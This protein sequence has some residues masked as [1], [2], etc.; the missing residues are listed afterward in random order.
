M[1]TSDHTTDAPAGDKLHKRVCLPRRAVVA[2]VLLA[3]VSAFAFAG[4][5][6]LGSLLFLLIVGLTAFAQ[7]E[8]I[9]SFGRMFGQ[10]RRD[11][12]GHRGSHLKWWWSGNAKMTDPEGKEEESAPAWY[13]VALFL[14]G[15]GPLAVTML[16]SPLP[17]WLGLI[18]VAILIALYIYAIVL[19][20]RG[21][22]KSVTAEDEP[23][24]TATS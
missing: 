16:A 4:S 23:A 13:L 10:V 8:D 7:L 11:G 20:R 12:K 6:L 17:T 15:F 21:R 24:E 22:T 19:L 3:I 18:L 9:K 2:L 5:L 14:L 1:E